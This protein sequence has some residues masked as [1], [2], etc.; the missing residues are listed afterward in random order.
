MVPLI[1]DA[2]GARYLMG[3]T[4]TAQGFRWAQFQ[5]PGGG[6][7]APLPKAGR[8]L[9]ATRPGR[10]YGSGASRAPA[11]TAGP[12]ALADYRDH[13]ASCSGIGGLRAP[14]ASHHQRLDVVYLDTLADRARLLGARKKIA[15][16]PDHVMFSARRHRVHVEAGAG[17]RIGQAE[18]RRKL[19]HRG[20]KE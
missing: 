4:E 11:L 8:A 10:P 5:F 18:V 17:E 14:A 7:R 6:V 13:P 12:E 19:V 1:R 16:D 3:A 2:L 15:K 9:P 20:L